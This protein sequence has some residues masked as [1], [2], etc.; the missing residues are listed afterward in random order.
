M[1]SLA[2]HPQTS[3]R[4]GKTTSD[5]C[6]RV[7][8]RVVPGRRPLTGDRRPQVSSR[9]AEASKGTGAGPLASE[10]ATASRIR[11]A[12]GPIIA[13][14][15]GSRRLYP[16]KV[17]PPRSLGS[18]RESSSHQTRNVFL[19]PSNPIKNPASKST[20]SRGALPFLARLMTTSSGASTNVAN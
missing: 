7:S 11:V 14:L 3:R 12:A 6:Y 17:T 8:L 20:L 18:S 5:H 16:A 10:V 2:G 1:T 4:A 13:W 15:G 19:L 9:S